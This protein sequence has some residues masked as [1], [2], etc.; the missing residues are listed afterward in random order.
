MP[1]PL[2]LPW[3][4]PLPWDELCAFFDWPWF[5]LFFFVVADEE[6]VCFGL[7][8]LGAFGAFGAGEC[9]FGFFAFGVAVV[10]TACVVIVGVVVTGHV[11]VVS[12]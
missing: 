11:P 12:P 5:E 3:P 2:S 7:V 9:C 1:L 10:A 8:G 4:T 6:E